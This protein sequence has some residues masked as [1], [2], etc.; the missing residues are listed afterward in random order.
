LLKDFRQRYPDAVA[1]ASRLIDRAQA[2]GE[3]WPDWCWLPMAGFHAYVTE[4]AVAPAMEIPRVSALTTWR[5]GRGVYLPDEEVAGYAAGTLRELTAEG[6]ADWEQAVMP[7]TAAW[8]ALPEWCCYIAFPPGIIRPEVTGILAGVLAPAG[9]FVHLEHDVNT[10][11]PELRL[12]LDQDGTWDGLIPIPVYLDRPTLGAAM[13]D[14][15]AVERSV[16]AGVAG[17]DVRSLSGPNPLDSMR[18]L[19]AWN[20]LPLILSLIDPDARYIDPALPGD[21]PAAAQQRSDGLWRP[22]S[23]TRTWQVTYR[24]PGPH[25]RLA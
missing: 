24:T 8:A 9:V 22:A 1:A 23:R 10:G 12:L 11:R 18:G 17:A 16:L 4:R 15:G 6:A 2:A 20:V 14:T 7:D 19:A 13:A 3:I 25:L 5:L 21:A